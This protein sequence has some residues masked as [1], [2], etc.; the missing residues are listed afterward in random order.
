[1]QLKGMLTGMN[2]EEEGE[3]DYDDEEYANNSTPE[4]PVKP[5]IDSTTA[6]IANEQF[7]EAA[8]NSKSAPQIQIY[9]G[10]QHTA[11]VRASQE[12]TA[13]GE[14]SKPAIVSSSNSKVL[15]NDV[16]VKKV[17]KAKDTTPANLKIYAQPVFRRSKSEVRKD[18]AD[19][20]K[21]LKDKQRDAEIDEKI[22]SQ[23][24]INRV[25]SPDGY[26][27]SAEVDALMYRVT[28]TTK[29]AL[30]KS[31]SL[32]GDIAAQ[33]KKI[34]KKYKQKQRPATSD[35]AGDDNGYA[36]FTDHSSPK[37][38]KQQQ[39]TATT[40]SG[41][42]G[43]TSKLQQSK[44]RDRESSSGFLPP[45]QSSTPRGGGGGGEEEEGGR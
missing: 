7:F 18:E 12:G 30:M 38:T 5:V 10:S 25:S 21:R 19:K 44:G 2:T 11:T 6:N 31:S 39:K 9:D 20:H 23:Q 29:T 28:G 3:E 14:H 35:G 45:V 34:M 17:E 37:R 15:N 40:P 27:K 24:M 33:N 42:K 8:Q 16:K 36:D 41:A 1:M 43:K 13:M 22:R 32:V 4:R 26:G